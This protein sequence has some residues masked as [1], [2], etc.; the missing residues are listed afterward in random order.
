MKDIKISIGPKQEKGD[1]TPNRLEAVRDG[2]ND[3]F[4]FLGI[5]NPDQMARCIEE[6]YTSH[7]Y[8]TFFGASGNPYF[9]QERE[10]DVHG[11]P[12]NPISE[13][14]PH[15]NK[16]GIGSINEKSTKEDVLPNDE[17]Y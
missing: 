4:V 5:F 12:N 16:S 14:Q 11:V 3:E 1:K 10:V 2:F 17:F 15:T 9:D 8:I 7:Y 13:V 6:F